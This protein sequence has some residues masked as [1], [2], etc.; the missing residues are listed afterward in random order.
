MAVSRV[1]VEGLDA[2]TRDLRATH[3]Q[4]PRAMATVHRTVAREVAGEARSFARGHGGST[5]HFAGTIYGIGSAKKAAISNRR[6]GNAAIWGAKK[7]TGWNAGRR[8]RGGR[9]QHPKWVGNSWDVGGSGGPRGI[10][11]AIRHDLPHIERRFL[12]VAAEVARRAFP[13]GR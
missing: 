7:R 5:A 2:F 9:P 12:E 11:D 3:S 10:N 1:H 4:W 6:E 8:N 13:K